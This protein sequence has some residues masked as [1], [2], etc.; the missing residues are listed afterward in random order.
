MACEYKSRGEHNHVTTQIFQ[1]VE[2]FAK[3]E[4][5][6]EFPDKQIQWFEV[7][8]YAK[9]VLE[10]AGVITQTSFGDY[11]IDYDNGRG[12]SAQTIRDVNDTAKKYFGTSQ[13]ML[14][15]SEWGDRPQLFFANEV[16]KNLYPVSDD[17][18]ETQTAN[19]PHVSRQGYEEAENQQ[20]PIEE[21]SGLEEDEMEKEDEVPNQSIIDEVFARKNEK[22]NLIEQILHNLTLQIERL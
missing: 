8:D 20:D 18:A 16:V 12:K 15:V 5:S 7:T 2:D 21:P 13:D 6:S 17:I 19:I 14:K 1:F 4:M 9:K 10:D 3:G 22:N 11:I